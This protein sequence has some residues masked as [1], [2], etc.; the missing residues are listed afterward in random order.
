MA[1]GGRL[2]MSVF[3][4]WLIAIVRG[5]AGDVIVAALFNW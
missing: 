3:H 4:A 5:A 2:L 1:V